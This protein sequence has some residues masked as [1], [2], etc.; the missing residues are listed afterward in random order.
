MMEAGKSGDNLSA[1]LTAEEAAR[2]LGLTSRRVRQ[3]IAEG[4][5]E[6]ERKGERMWLIKRE[7]VEAY[8]QS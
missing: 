1:W 6:A 4:K 3:L 5:L 2:I 8:E 7:S